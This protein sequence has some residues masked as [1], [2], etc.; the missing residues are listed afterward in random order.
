MRKARLGD[1]AKT[2]TRQGLRCLPALREGYDCSCR[3]VPR[4]LESSQVPEREAGES[5]HSPVYRAAMG[6]KQMTLSGEEIRMIIAARAWR[7]GRKQG[8]EANTC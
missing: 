6:G 7:T 5:H 2:T 4:M 8:P 3:D 1:E